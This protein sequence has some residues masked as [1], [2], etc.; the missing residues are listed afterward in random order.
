MELL[1][2]AGTG[3]P[4]IVLVDGMQ[5]P[6]HDATAT[7]AVDIYGRFYP[8]DGVPVFLT[9]GTNLVFDRLSGGSPRK[10]SGS[11][12]VDIDSLSARAEASGH[13]FPAEEI[14]MPPQE[15]LDKQD[16]SWAN[17]FKPG[18]G[19]GTPPYPQPPVSDVAPVVEADA[20]QEV[21]TVTTP[22]EWTNDPR[23]GVLQPPT[24]Q[25]QLNAVD[26]VGATATVYNKTNNTDEDQALTVIETRAND[27]G[28]TAAA[29]SNALT[30]SNTMLVGSATGANPA[31]SM[32]YHG[33]GAWAN[34]GSMYLNKQVD[35]AILLGLNVNNNT[36]LFVMYFSAAHPNP[37]ASYTVWLDGTP[38][39]LLPETTS[40]WST[41]DARAHGIIQSFF[42]ADMDVL[43]ERG[44]AVNS[45]FG[46]DFSLAASLAQDVAG[47]TPVAA[48]GDPIGAVTTGD[49][50]L[51]A[52]ADDTTRPTWQAA[53]Q[54][55]LGGA[56]HVA[57][58]EQML[59]LIQGTPFI[60]SAH[61]S[62]FVVVSQQIEVNNK[63]VFSL[64]G[65]GAVN[66][67]DNFPSIAFSQHVT[68]GLS[69]R[70]HTSLD[71]LTEYHTL[72]AAVL[73]E[74]NFD[75][76]GQATTF[77]NGVA[78][79]L[80]LDAKTLTNLAPID[81][82][83]GVRG[84]TAPGDYGFWGDVT[85]GEFRLIDSPTDDQIVAERGRLMAKWGLT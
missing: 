66:D 48:D 71:W 34:Q 1:S 14:G 5:Q 19:T 80:N 79:T 12:L 47:T 55:G 52:N 49:I 53:F 58:S 44:E 13:V 45:Y 38:F 67:W 76:A 4:D 69:A 31:T 32:G 70:R 43:I 33:S 60:D 40:R 35:G 74:V 64:R 21:F 37:P 78:Q 85:I 7:M 17:Q 28:A 8:L 59:S 16:P 56:K 27:V 65:D 63:G 73:M 9:T 75:A 83:T 68:N 10:T 15:W 23:S 50:L 42:G 62:I 82:M 11:G 54:N 77:L 25:W 39:V 81:I 84:L 24:Y 26:I 51:L 29:P 20:L 61:F 36:D 18:Y 3:R 57:L 6:S 2:K 41:I 46:T 72:N 22:G 30:A